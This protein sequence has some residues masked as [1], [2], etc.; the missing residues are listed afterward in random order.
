MNRI[1][2]LPIVISG[3]SGAGKTTLIDRLV[4]SDPR[5]K[6]SVSVTT[7]P[8][9]NGE[10]EGEAY[11]FVTPERFEELKKTELVEWA[12]VHGCLY[13]TPGL[14]VRETLESGRDVVLNIDI[15]GGIA[16]KKAFPAAVMIFILPPSFRELRER[17]ERRGADRSEDIAVR[18]DNARAEV[19]AAGDYEYLVIND[20]LDSAVADLKAIIAAERCKRERRLEDFLDRFYAK[21]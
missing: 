5:L 18:L 7:R 3:P 14:Y 10:V 16:I 20:D 15:Q 1:P 9:R 12:E 4:P 8:P 17:I 11:F 19:S 2:S 13:G 21:K 6:L